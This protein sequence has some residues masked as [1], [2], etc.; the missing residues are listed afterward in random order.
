VSET[1]DLAIIEQRT[2]TFYE[3]ELVAIRA[4]DGHVYVAVSQ[5]CDAL[6]IDSQAQTRR[7]D[8]TTVLEEGLQ[9]VADLATP[10]GRQR[11]YVLRV[12]LVPLW[13]SGIRTR[14]VGEEARPKLERFQREAAKVLWEAFQEGRLTGEPSFSE[15]A[16]GD[17]PAAVAYRMAA[18]VMRLAR[19][20]LLLE[21]QQQQHAAQLAAQE[22]RLER[23]EAVLGDPGRAI[24]PGQATRIS[25]AV[26]A[27]A[28]T[29][30]ERS[31]RNEYG[32]VYGEFYRR[33]EIPSYRELPAARFD[34]AMKFLTEWYQQAAGTS[35]VPF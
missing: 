29:L 34:E 20:Q 10:G 9:E 12:D 17:S 3:D 26:K 23:V 18:A 6:G 22:R 15:L 13:L 35:D 4:V 14:M 8:R 32:G 5:M 11:A 33:F 19:Q 31:G 28:M 2:V 7:I 21:E 30:G 24:T 27:I 25:Q 16:E 1:K